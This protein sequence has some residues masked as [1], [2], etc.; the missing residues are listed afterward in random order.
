VK[1]KSSVEA[2]LKYFVVAKRV[3]RY[4]QM[5]QGRPMGSQAL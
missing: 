4:M 2:V 5:K 1:K 3:V